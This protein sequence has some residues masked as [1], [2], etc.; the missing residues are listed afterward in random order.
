MILNQS[1]ISTERVVI[2]AKEMMNEALSAIDLEDNWDK[3]FGNEDKM[4]LQGLQVQ[5]TKRKLKHRPSPASSW[6]L[7]MGKE[8]MD[9]WI[10]I[11]NAHK[12]FMDGASKVN[13]G[14]FGVGGIIMDT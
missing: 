14:N 3:D 10:K 9:H 7:R 5:T 11:Q 8:E 13:P 6:I 1:H 4:W 12:I 2:K